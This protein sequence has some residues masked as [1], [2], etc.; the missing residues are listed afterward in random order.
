MH[1]FDADI[2]DLA[3][4]AT[5]T[6]DRPA[7][8]GTVSHV[9]RRAVPAEQ[10]FP[11]AVD[12]AQPSTVP[13]SQKV[14]VKTFGCSHNTSDAEFMAGQLAEY[15]YDL[16]NDSD[17]ATADL[18]L[19]NSCTVKGPSQSAVGNLVTK[20]RKNGKHIVVSG[21]VPQGDR[22]AKE[23]EGISVLGVT[24]ID[25][26]VEAVEETLKG[27]TVQLLA[28]KALPRLDLPKVRRNKH[29][30]IIPLSTGCLGAC[31]YCKTK[32]ARGELGSYA[33]EA[34]VERVRAAVADPLVREIWLSSEDTGAYGRD[35]GTSL[36]ELLRA[37]LAEMPHD[38]STMLRVGMTNPPYMLEHLAAIADALKHPAC[39][40]YLHI[41]VQS[42]SD[43]VLGGMN[44]EYTVAEFERVCDELLAAVP[45]LELATDIIAGFPGEGPQDHVDTLRLLRK[46]RFPHCHISQFYPRP[47]TPAAR[48]KR[49]PTDVVKARS[50]EITTEVDSWGTAYDHL[51]GTVQQCCVVD[52]AAD[53]VSLV[54]HN[55]TYAQVLL[56]PQAPDGSG[57]LLGC[58]VK[59]KIIS[60]SRWS[61]K[62]EVLEVLYRPPVAAFSG[63]STYVVK[64]PAAVSPSTTSSSEAL[65][66]DNNQRDTRKNAAVKLEKPSS[67]G[68]VKTSKGGKLRRELTPSVSSN[69]AS[70]PAAS[71]TNRSPV[72]SG[73]SSAASAASIGKPSSF[74]NGKGAV[75]QSMPVPTTAVVGVLEDDSPGV[76]PVVQTLVWLGVVVGLSAILLSGILTL[77]Q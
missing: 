52:I 21:C 72:V 23:L 17:S 76:S 73:I 47:G 19:I 53:K 54:G 32:H 40:T 60:A 49:V 66:E 25:R 18:W 5:S 61:V 30:E 70:G 64:Q 16:V 57:N 6:T 67:L 59:A 29:V 56:P 3:F 50:R 31:T 63:K 35:L 12:A 28:K 2:E 51:V 22:R 68:S 62:G 69:S 74:M 20:A 45:E 58:V 37:M 14:W 1:D 65:A 27:N 9:S 11:A 77:L 75:V 34:L 39:F 7:P 46:Y 8:R 42:G 48:M 41:P 4:S 36:P 24:Q 15:G 55:K 38:G 33:P 10:S 71:L 13:G 26:V 43:A 44:R